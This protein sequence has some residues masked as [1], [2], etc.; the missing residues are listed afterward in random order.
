MQPAIGKKAQRL[1]P[2][3]ISLMQ[4]IQAVRLGCLKLPSGQTL[5]K[6]GQHAAVQT[7]CHHGAEHCPMLCEEQ[8]AAETHLAM[9][10][11]IAQAG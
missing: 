11:D 2:P 7:L 4:A 9:A 6:R 3:D 10:E 5:Q 1:D 8:G